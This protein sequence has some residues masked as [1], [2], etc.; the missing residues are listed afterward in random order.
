MPVLGEPVDPRLADGRRHYQLI[1]HVDEVID[2]DE[3]ADVVGGALAQHLEHETGWLLGAHP[4]G[5]LVWENVESNDP[6]RHR[7][8][9]PVVEVRRLFGLLAEGDISTIE[10]L[11]WQP[12][13]GT[14]VP[15]CAGRHGGRI[16]GNV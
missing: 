3:G 15:L 11:D 7:R 12:G 10:G 9:V 1:P 6:P 16:S 2:V 14:W 8:D 13:Y 4:S 5:I